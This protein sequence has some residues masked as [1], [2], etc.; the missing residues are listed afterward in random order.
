MSRKERARL[1]VVLVVAVL[2]AAL[3]GACGDS[4]STSGSDQFRDQTKS[5]LLD[6]GAE[7][8]GSE[9]E[10]VDATVS[11][12][13]AV[14]A[15]EDWGATCALLSKQMLDKLERLA[16]NSTSLHDT[17]CPA[18][19]DAFVVL[20][21]QEKRESAEIEGGSLRQQGAKGYLIYH[22]SE[23]V[24]Y[25]MPLEREGSAWKVAALSPQRLS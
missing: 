18:F 24:V 25:A 2:A 8:S 15:K 5:P 12:F 19:L 13:L 21:A 20:S 11:D 7:G 17:S 1:L 6:F 16:T 22:G 4:G 10:E 3:L 23:D 14:H 9:L